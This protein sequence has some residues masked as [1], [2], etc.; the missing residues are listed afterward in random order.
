MDVLDQILL[1]VSAV[2]AVTAALYAFR[3]DRFSRT[4]A[5]EAA[6]QRTADI[7]PHLTVTWHG[8]AA[9]GY[10]ILI[11]NA[12]GAAPRALWVGHD[13]GAVFSAHGLIPAHV[14]PVQVRVF[15]VPDVVYPA[16]GITSVLCLAQDVEGGRWNAF[17]GN[18][19]TVSAATFIRAELEA[20][21]VTPDAQEKIITALRAGS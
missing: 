14:P 15:L 10:K 11:G 2:A 1:I 9:S 21:G 16:P 3:G 20:V 18:P 13:G 19:V 7:Q 17:D 6:T 12:G 8:G 4:M 5:R